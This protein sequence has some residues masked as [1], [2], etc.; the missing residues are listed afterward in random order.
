MCMFWPPIY[1]YFFGY[2]IRNTD[3][4]TGGAD[5]TEEKNV[6]MEDIFE[7]FNESGSR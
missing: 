5:E 2:I 7:S 4:L 1:G 6:Q 3:K